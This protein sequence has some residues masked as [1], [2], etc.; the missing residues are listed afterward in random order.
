MLLFQTSG[1]TNLSL[2]EGKV[3]GKRPIARPR[4]T[5]IDDVTRWTAIESY[6]KNEKDS[7]G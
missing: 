5:W 2:L 1:K 6:E 4:P 3:N 7:G